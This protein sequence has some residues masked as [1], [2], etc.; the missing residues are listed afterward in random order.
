MPRIPLSEARPGQKLS[1]PAATRAGVVMV[2]AGT[3]LTPALIER[4]RLLGIDTVSVHGEAGGSSRPLEEVLAAIDARFAGHEGDPRM[5][6]LKEIVVRQAR[7]QDRTG[8]HG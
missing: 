3:E 6:A 7:E 4:L 1:R 8:D 2:Q 5:M